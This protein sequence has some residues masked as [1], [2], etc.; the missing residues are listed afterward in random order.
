MP[1]LNVDRWYPDNKYTEQQNFTAGGS[2][3]S[4]VISNTT[5][6][7][8]RWLIRR[9]TVNTPG[10]LKKGKVGERVNL[11]VNPFSYIEVHQKFPRG[12]YERLYHLGQCSYQRNIVDGIVLNDPAAWYGYTPALSAAEVAS[13]NAQ[14]VTKIRLKLKNQSVNLAQM[15]GERRQTANLLATTAVR[16]S[17]SFSSLKR[18]NLSGAA[19]ALGLSAS[20]KNSS[21]YK[22][23]FE[24]DPS[25][26]AANGWLELQ[27][28]WLPLLNDVYGSAELLAQKVSRQVFEKVSASVTANRKTIL[29]PATG[30]ISVAD[31]TWTSK[32]Y[33]WFGTS[34]VSHTLSQVGLTNPAH[35]AW[36]LLPYSFVVDWF[37]P[38]GNY[39]SSLDATLGLNFIKGGQTTFSRSNLTITES[40][41]ASD[42]AFTP[43]PACAGVF[44]YLVNESLNAVSS[45]IIVKCDR[46]PLFEF[47]GPSFPSFKNPLSM[48]HAANAIALLSQTFK[49]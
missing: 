25:K 30:V 10:F 37:L 14:L 20:A 43:H 7:G 42:G 1:S 2:S 21:R 29:R 49:R 39:L 19:R 12:R 17:A 40:R 38:V 15:Y 34:E 35:L 3:G 48:T 36:E 4:P 27:Y 22:T 24:R 18:G 31:L 44:A 23:R 11:P 6:D 41:S 32:M 26:A 46:V 8:S 33:L 47:P 45:Q 5:P 9:V 28:G 16:L 13:L